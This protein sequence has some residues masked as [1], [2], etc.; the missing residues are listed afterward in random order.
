MRAHIQLRRYGIGALILL[1]L[2]GLTTAAPRALAQSTETPRPAFTE[3]SRF[4]PTATQTPSTTPT[5][6][7]TPT[8]TLTPSRTP[9]PT[10]TPVPT[11]TLVPSRTP[12]VSNTPGASPTRGPTNTPGPTSAGTR[13]PTLVPG[14]DTY[15]VRFGD[16]LARIA[17]RFGITL[18]ALLGVNSLDNTATIYEGQILRIPTPIATITP[19]FSTIP[20]G[21][22][23]YRVQRNDQLL[24]LAR[25]FRTTTA[26]LRTAS[27]LSSDTIFEG[28]WLLIPPPNTPTVTPTPFPPGAQTYVVRIGDQLL[29]L[30]RRFGLTLTQLKSANGLTSDTVQPG[31]VLFIPTPLPTST[32]RPPTVTPT[33]VY[34]A[35]VVRPGDRLQRIAVWYG[36]TMTAI[37]NANGLSG[38]VLR[39]GRTLTIPNPTRRP[40]AYTVQPGDTL[41][42]L[43]ARF[44]TTV[45]AL[46]ISND[47]GKG[48]TILA[49]LNLI[50]P[51][52]P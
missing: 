6:Q 38:D 9:S 31:R 36:V 10:R 42:S 35:Y 29:A 48:E 51:T 2:V 17:Q 27:N 11:R 39:V 47:M 50:I 41:I 15:T 26:Q 16:T 32:P 3:T 52:K 19:P 33:G 13:T 25:R 43:A 22:Q 44:E 37:R 5:S 46:Q 34:V 4:Q 21:Y 49:G 40:I 1:A 20:P 12:R 14:P 28:Q 24:A 7:F 30:A 23:L 8:I 18:G 45:E